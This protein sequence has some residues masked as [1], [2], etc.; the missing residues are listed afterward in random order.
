MTNNEKKGFNN[1]YYEAWKDATKKHY[2]IL[3]DLKEKIKTMSHYESEDGQD[4][5]MVADVG[6]CIDEYINDTE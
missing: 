6:Q 4:L 1:G 2:A 5:V 3:E